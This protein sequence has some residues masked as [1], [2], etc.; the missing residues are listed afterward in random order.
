VGSVVVFEQPESADKT[1]MRE[2]KAFMAGVT[3]TL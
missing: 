1:N 3:I 2:T